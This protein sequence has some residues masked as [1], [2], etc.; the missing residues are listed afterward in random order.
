MSERER[1]A[2]EGT[3]YDLQGPIFPRVYPVKPRGTR[4]VDFY[5]MDQALL[6]S[7]CYLQRSP[8]IF[9]SQFG[10]GENRQS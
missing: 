10:S 6:S 5:L 8:K 7:R 4:S 1:K 3:K 9:N 2:D